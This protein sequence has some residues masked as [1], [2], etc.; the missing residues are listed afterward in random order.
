LARS[1]AILIP[2][3]EAVLKTSPT[4]GTST[5]EQELGPHQIFAI[6]G[7]GNFHIKFGRTGMG[8]AAATDFLIPSNTIVVLDTGSAFTHV[9][10]FNPTGSTINL[11]ILPLSIV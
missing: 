7:D 10:L 9:R 11:Y 5:T 1:D 3:G 4:T 2:S 8:A 6:V